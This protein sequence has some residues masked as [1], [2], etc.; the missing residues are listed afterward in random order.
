MIPKRIV[1]LVERFEF[2]GE[3]IDEKGGAAWEDGVKRCHVRWDIGEI[4]LEK[5]SGHGGVFSG[6]PGDSAS[7]AADEGYLDA[8]GRRTEDI[9]NDRRAEGV[10]NAQARGDAREVA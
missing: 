5:R 8:A 10:K 6:E 4:E 9:G 7:V 2:V 3:E 1:K